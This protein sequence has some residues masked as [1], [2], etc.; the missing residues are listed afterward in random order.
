MSE[1]IMKI[2]FSWQKFMEWYRRFPRCNKSL[3]YF[4]S[5]KLLY[6]I[7]FSLTL[8]CGFVEIRPP[9]SHL[10]LKWNRSIF[11]IASPSFSI[12]FMKETV[13]LIDYTNS[14]AD[15]KRTS[16]CRQ[17][18]WNYYDRSYLNLY[19]LMNLPCFI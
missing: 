18:K 11:H 19:P 17:T 6:G 5:Y 8:S 12:F 10:N 4:F 9:Q 1:S 3:N 13:R 15:K 14:I 2:N 7:F 16:L